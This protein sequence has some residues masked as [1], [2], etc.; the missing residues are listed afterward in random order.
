MINPRSNFGVEILDGTL[1]AVGGFN[2]FQTTYN[3]E[4]YD[5]EQDRLKPI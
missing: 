2:G 3:V 4:S 1:M 5:N